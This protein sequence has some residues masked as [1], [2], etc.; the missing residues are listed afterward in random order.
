MNIS[1]D[2]LET[3]VAHA[4]ARLAELREALNEMPAVLGRQ[5]RNYDFYQSLLREDM[6]MQEVKRDTAASHLAEVFK[7][8]ELKPGQDA[9]V[10]VRDLFNKHEIKPTQQGPKTHE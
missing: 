9:R 8:A 5:F 1:F 7:G 2:I 3:Q 10:V 4:E 6:T